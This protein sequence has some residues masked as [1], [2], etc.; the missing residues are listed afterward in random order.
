MFYQGEWIFKVSPVIFLCVLI[1]RPPP[2]KHYLR[3][4][5]VKNG[6]S[7][8]CCIWK[9]WDASRVARREESE[10][11][12]ILASELGNVPVLHL[13][14]PH[15]GLKGASPSKSN[16]LHILTLK[17][18]SFHF[19]STLDHSGLKMIVR[20]IFFRFLKKKSGFSVPHL[21]FFPRTF[22]CS[23]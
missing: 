9:E 4:H 17:I 19:T 20:Q 14:Y 21:K 10:F 16:F 23:G 6:A 13:N 7:W 12:E 11:H 2:L 3:P 22:F 18:H 8:R 15:F 5:F 1:L